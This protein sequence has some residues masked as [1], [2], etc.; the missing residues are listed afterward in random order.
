MEVRGQPLGDGVS[1][2]SLY[3]MDHKDSTLVIRLG[4]K[5]IYLLSYLADSTFK[6]LKTKLLISFY[7]MKCMTLRSR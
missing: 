6:V 3:H 4:G 1:D 5:H 7:E 2:L